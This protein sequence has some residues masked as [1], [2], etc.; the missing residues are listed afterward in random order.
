MG[1]TWTA[2][3]EVSWEIS[4]A[5]GEGVLERAAGGS[6]Q[7]NK[8]Q[9][10]LVMKGSV[11]RRSCSGPEKSQLLRYIHGTYNYHLLFK[12]RFMKNNALLS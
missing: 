1:Y 12:I 8:Q 11:S 3:G 7:C 6:P 9:Q 4:D 2:G 5:L 10:Q